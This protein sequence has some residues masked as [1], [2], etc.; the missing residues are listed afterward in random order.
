[1]IKE[2]IS[3]VLFIIQFYII[4]GSPVDLMS[5]MMITMHMVQMA[6]LLL[7]MPILLIKG[8]P[9][10]IW[11]TIF[12]IKIINQLFTLF[13]KPLIAMILFNGAFSIYHIPIVLD[14]SKTSNVY[15]ALIHTTLFVFAFFMFWP[16]LTPFKEKSMTGLMKTGYMFGNGALMLPA[17]ALII[18]AGSPLYN[19]YSDP[20]AW[21]N[22]LALCSTPSSLSGLGSAGPALISIFNPLGLLHDQQLAGIVMKIIQE[23][24]YIIIIATIFKEWYRKD[25][26]EAREE[27]ERVMLNQK[28]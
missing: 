3:F 6:C 10:W 17:C 4:K 22:A 16:V 1:M 19:T 26:E 21:L 25:A 9:G 24:V 5:H 13:T 14:F 18:F 23:I 28:I 11:K 7:I 12:N 2:V 8:I 20:V 27:T 15:H